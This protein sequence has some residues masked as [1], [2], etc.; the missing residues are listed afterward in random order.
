MY[1]GM[2]D[3][4]DARARAARLVRSALAERRRIERSLHDGAEQDLVAISVR[5]QLVRELVEA[6]P[7]DALALLDDVRA[8]TANAL[9][10]LRTLAGDV[11]PPVL[12]ARGL[13]AALRSIPGARVESSGL[14]RYPA[15]I[16]AAVYFACRSVVG[17]DEAAILVREEHGALDL[18]VVSAG[19][20]AAAEAR[21]LVVAVG[22]TLTVDG[23][24]VVAR[25]PLRA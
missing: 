22:G 20:V 15:E 7:A 16:E 9:A 12:E 6:A 17:Q 24:R 13:G 3:A 25:F 10:R 2:D 21:D 11:Y 18:E 4:D 5:L 19:E 23:T 14:G 1:A 8:E